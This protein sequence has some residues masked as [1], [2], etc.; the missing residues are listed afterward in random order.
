MQTLYEDYVRFYLLMDYSRNESEFYASIILETDE[1]PEALVSTHADPSRVW[2]ACGEGL[3]QDGLGE[4]RQPL[5]V[6]PH[7][8]QV[9]EAVVR[10]RAEGSEVVRHT[11]IHTCTHTY[12]HA[13]IQVRQ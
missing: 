4:E 8:F 11:Y 9:D 10:V 12:M 13:Y 3:E 7:G 6:Q 2:P 1:E 5:E